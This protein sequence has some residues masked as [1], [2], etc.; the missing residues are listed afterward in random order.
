MKIVAALLGV[1]VG[2]LLTFPFMLVH[3]N[4]EAGA[5]ILFPSLPRASALELLLSSIVLYGVWVSVLMLITKRNNRLSSIILFLFV[6]P[7]P[8]MVIEQ[9][10]F[11]SSL[12]SGGVH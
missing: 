10:L 12:N 4:I 11:N 6:L 2:C 7:L 8:P 3:V 1:V 5:H 9:I